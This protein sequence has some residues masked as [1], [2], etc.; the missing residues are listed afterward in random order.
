MLRARVLPHLDLPVAMRLFGP[1]TEAVTEPLADWIR[2]KVGGGS[3]TDL[4]L[5]LHGRPD[6]WDLLDWPGAKLLAQARAAGAAVALVIPLQTIPKMEFSEKMDLLRVQAR[7]DATLHG[8]Q[9]MPE[10]GGAPVLAEIGI[11][12]MRVAFASGAPHA[13]EMGPRW[14]EVAEQPILRS[15]VAGTSIGP[16]LSATKLAKFSEGNSVHGGVT[17]DL[18][19]PIEGFGAAFWK[20]VAQLRPQVVARERRLLSATYSDRYLRSPLTVRLLAEVLKKLPRRSDDT[21]IEI[22]SQEVEAGRFARLYVLHDNWSDDA[23]REGVLRGCVPGATVALKPKSGCPHARS[24]SLEF[25]D[26]SRVTVHLDQGLGSWRTT[27]HR[28]VPFDGQAPVAAQVAALAKVRTNV[29][30]QDSGIAPSPIWVTW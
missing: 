5:F 27:G 11:D 15:A 28:P 8:L 14:G 17:G 6:E 30:M 12:G 26:G 22:V 1:G 13:A 18:D 24:L 7:G 25:D 2:R 20:K 9:A 29:E 21:R 4:T 10:V 3:M 16:A 19:G 23:V